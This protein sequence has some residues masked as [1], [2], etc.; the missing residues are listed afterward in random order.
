[1]QELSYPPVNQALLAE[2]VQRLKSA[3]KPLKIGRFCMKNQ[4]DLAVGWFR[5]A[6]GDLTTAPLVVEIFNVPVESAECGIEGKRGGFNV[7]RTSVS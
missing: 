2:V 6:E 3:G 5:K 7:L 4:H 1:M